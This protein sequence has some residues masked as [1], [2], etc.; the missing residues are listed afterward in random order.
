MYWNVLMYWKCFLQFCTNVTVWES[1][2]EIVWWLSGTEIGKGTFINRENMIRLS[3]NL[4]SPRWESYWRWVS[5]AGVWLQWR[6]SWNS[7]IPCYLCQKQKQKTACEREH[8]Q[9]VCDLWWRAWSWT[10]W[11]D[12]LSHFT[13]D[14]I[15]PLCP[16]LTSERKNRAWPTAHNRGT[17]PQSAPQTSHPRNNPFI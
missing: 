16:G 17:K 10:S 6:P 13:N 12:G 1:E 14:T 2:N 9:L 5:A 7:K 4:P 8:S 3:V 11:P 15:H